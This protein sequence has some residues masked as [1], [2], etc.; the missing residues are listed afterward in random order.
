MAGF[1]QGDWSLMVRP[2]WRI[3][4]KAS[5]DNNPGIGDYL[6][7]AEAVL[8]RRW[9]EQILSLQVRHSLRSGSNSRGSGQVDWA[10]PITGNLRGHLQVFSGY[11]ERLID[12]NFK[13]TRLGVGVV[14][15]EWR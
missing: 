13:Q 1:E 8:T 6:G 9:G 7:R 15:V 2:W 3:P 11:G 14:L 5:V 4:E 12:Y 10:Y